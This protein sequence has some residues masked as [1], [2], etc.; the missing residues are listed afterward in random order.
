MVYSRPRC[1]RAS[2]SVMLQHLLIAAVLV[3]ATVAL[4][5]LG[6]GLMLSGLLKTRHAPPSRTWP[7][8]WLL[9]RLAWLFI[10]FHVAAIAVWA[11]FYWWMKCLPTAESAFYFSGVTYTT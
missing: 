3:A 10:L 2:A 6:F 9:I 1:S 4:H 5:A 11:L 8:S 7:I